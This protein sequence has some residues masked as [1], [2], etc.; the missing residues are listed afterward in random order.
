MNSIFLLLMLSVLVILFAVLFV[1]KGWHYRMLRFKYCGVLNSANLTDATPSVCS[2]DKKR[3]RAGLLE[4]RVK[5][6]PNW[7]K[8]HKFWTAS[9]TFYLIFLVISILYEYGIVR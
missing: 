3:K 6:Q 2:T 5:K 7:F 1:R 8:K 4:R 9:I